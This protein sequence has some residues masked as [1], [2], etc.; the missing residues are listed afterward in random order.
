MSDPDDD[1][2]LADLFGPITWPKLVL[3]GMLLAFL[4]GML[5]ICAWS[6]TP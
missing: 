3:V 5:A 6:P 4:L 2:L 1:S